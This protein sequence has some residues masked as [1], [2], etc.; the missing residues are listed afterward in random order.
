[1]N[2]PGLGFSGKSLHSVLMSLFQDSKVDSLEWR[3]PPV[4]NPL[5]GLQLDP[6]FDASILHTQES[7]DMGKNLYKAINCKNTTN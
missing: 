1:M 3:C 4:Q 7:E 6:L 2:S 5:L